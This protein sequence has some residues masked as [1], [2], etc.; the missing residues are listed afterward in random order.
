MHQFLCRAHRCMST[1][2][3]PYNTTQLR[4][5]IWRHQCHQIPLR[6][7]RHTHARKPGGV[8]ATKAESLTVTCMQSRYISLLLTAGCSRTIVFRTTHKHMHTSLGAVQWYLESR[9]VWRVSSRQRRLDIQPDRWAGGD[10]VK[11]S[12]MDSCTV[13]WIC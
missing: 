10:N 4:L 2:I 7:Q 6:I 9:L 3:G 8:F 12:W 5:I 11:D 13:A 1:K